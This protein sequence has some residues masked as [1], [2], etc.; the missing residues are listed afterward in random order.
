MQQR[1]YRTL[2]CSRNFVAGDAAQRKAE[3][4]HIL[5]A[6]RFNN[7]R[8]GVTGALL[9]NSGY[10]AQVLEGPREAVEQIFEKIQ[11]D[12]RHGDVTVLESGYGDDRDLLSGRWLM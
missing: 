1:V 12:D 9:F 3:I 8:K 10:F 5:T 11:R 7:S 4:S 2:Y 6:A